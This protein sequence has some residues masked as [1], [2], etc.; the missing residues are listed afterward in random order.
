MSQAST[1]GERIKKMWH[2]YTGE[3]YSALKRKAILIYATIWG[4]PE[5]LFSDIKHRRTDMPDSTDMR[6][7]SLIHEA[8]SRTEV[9][10]AARSGGE[11]AYCLMGTECILRMRKTALGIV[12][13][14]TKLQMQLISLIYILKMVKMINITLHTF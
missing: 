3:C 4:E 1:N 5:N 2:M 9:P 6:Y 7:R 13:G 14:Y 8:E 10:R 12:S 11:S